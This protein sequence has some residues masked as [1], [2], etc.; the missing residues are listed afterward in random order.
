MNFF[1]PHTVFLGVVHIP[2]LTISLYSTILSYRVTR[3]RR[4]ELSEL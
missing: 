3:K 4:M 1:N 2:L